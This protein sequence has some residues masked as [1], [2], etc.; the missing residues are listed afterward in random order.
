MKPRNLSATAIWHERLCKSV[1]KWKGKFLVAAMLVVVNTSGFA[2]PASRSADDIDNDGLADSWEARYSTTLGLS[3]RKA[4]LIL[5]PVIRPNMTREEVEPTLRKVVEFFAR[6]P[7]RNP[8]GSTGIDVVIRWGNSLPERYRESEHPCCGCQ[9]L[10]DDPY[11]EGMPAEMIGKGHGYFFGSCTNGG[12][13]TFS[14][15][16]FSSNWSVGSNN[17]HTVAHEIG[18][19]LGLQH[20]PRGTGIPSP[21]YASIMNYDYDDQFNGD[22]NAVQFSPGKFSSLRLDE[23]NCSE[24]LPFALSDLNFLSRD[25][26]NF[27]LRSAGTRLTHVDFN[28]NGV[29]GETEIKAEINGGTALTAREQIDFEKTAGGIAL[30][31]LDELL[32]AI[33]AE[34]PSSWQ[35]YD[36]PGPSVRS[37]SRL[38]Y[39][40]YSDALEPGMVLGPSGVTGDPH[41]ISAFG[42]LFVAFSTA[43]GYSIFSYRREGRR[44]T[45]LQLAGSVEITD[46]TS[47]YPLLVRTASPEELYVFLWDKDTK[48]VRYRRVTASSSPG[49][50]SLGP[51]TDLSM[52][53]GE[54]ATPIVSN[55]SIGGTWNSI[56]GRIILVT[57]HATGGWTGRMK[58]LQVVRAGER[59]HGESNRW[60]FIGEEQASATLSRPSVIFDDRPSA[61]STGRYLIYS[62]I[63]PRGTETAL[64]EMTQL[65]EGPTDAW[66]RQ[67]MMNGWTLTRSA[68]SAVM[69]GD[70]IAWAW[71]KD[72]DLG[73]GR[74]GGLHNTLHVYL[75]ASGITDANL[76]DFDDVSWLASHGLRHSLRRDIWRYVGTPCSG[77]SCPGWQ[78]LD[79]NTAT[80]TISAG[81]AELYQLHN[82]GL[83]WR[84]TGTPCSGGSCS[85]WQLLDKN[86]RTKAI[87]ASATQLYQQH[88][89]GKI[90]RYT[91]TPCNGDSCPGWELLDVNANT[92]AIV[93]GG[94]ELYQLHTN[95][96]IWRYTGMPCSGGICPGWQLLDRN[97]NTMRI[98]A[99]SAGE[100][101]QLHRDGLIWNYTGTPCMGDSCP[102]WRLLDRNPSTKAI[103]AGR[104]T[105]FQLHTNG[106]I[107]SYTGTPCSGDRCTGWRRLDRNSKTTGI[108]AA[109][110]GELYQIHNDGLVWRYTGTACSGDACPGWQ[111][112]DNNHRTTLIDAGGDLYQLHG[113]P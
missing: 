111:L 67:L 88:T 35:T 15:N 84:Y 69:Y 79:G 60:V 71:R 39:Q 73:E 78:Q 12:G 66:T 62:V 76:T 70:D 23:R 43:R 24:T 58:M 4:N 81:G 59:W 41:A 102:G 109:S 47:P 20:E 22:P 77:G 46:A 61:G 44:P 29:F 36:G 2:E 101:Y 68:S 64:M 9:V 112:L 105:L 91:G 80:K 40:I 34:P 63:E 6:V 104:G 93:A 107:W 26:Y 3:P 54:A 49:A 10:P 87:I 5:V 89:D 17:W 13:Q 75:S 85:G 57:T 96:T 28:R 53:I 1:P 48:R 16:W 25:P 110:N 37:P 65:T 30:A 103:A 74:R 98:V 42:N 38:R 100:L 82:D 7:N 90:W 113:T 32:V 51:L 106:S 27:S 31:T 11:R 95:G 99:G 56:N 92:S 108:V 33:H 55:S 45:R 86:A 18:H 21:F 8:D 83:I 52:G 72:D 19:Q 14:S 97:P 94:A 50:I